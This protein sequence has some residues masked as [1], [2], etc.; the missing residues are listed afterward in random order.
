[1]AGAWLDSR[2]VPGPN[3]LWARPCAVLDLAWDDAD[4]PRAVAAWQS[5]AR[6]ILDAVGWQREDTAV[7]L[8]PGG[9]TLALSAPDDALYAATELN[10]WAWTA[11][12]ADLAGQA[13]VE[14]LAAAAARL[15]ARIAAESRPRMMALKAEAARRG[16][17]FMRDD[18]YVS[19]GMGRWSRTWPVAAHPD[20]DAV[21]WDELGNLPVAVVTGTNGKS[22]T[23]R[24]L[25]AMC[26]AAGKVGGVTSTDFVK[27]GEETVET[28]D[29]AG[30]MGARL[31]LRHRRV[32]VAI[33]ETAR[34]GMLRRGLGMPWADAACIT[35]IAPDHLGEWG[36]ADLDQLADVKFIVRHAARRLV[37]NAEDA[38]TLERAP[39]CAQ[40]ITWF[41]TRD[42]I[43]FLRAHAA[44]NGRACVADDAT[45]WWCEGPRREAVLPLAEVPL[46]LGGAA[47][48]NVANA[49]AAAAVALGIGL[50]LAAVRDG[51]RS[52]RSDAAANPGRLN[53][54]ELGGVRALVDFAHNPH[55]Q[56]AL[57]ALARALPARRRLVMI[58]HAGDRSDADIR[59]VALTAARAGL[60]R[61]LI[62]EQAAHLRGRAPGEIPGIMR[63]ALRA[64]GFPDERVGMHASELDATRAALAWAQP[65]D[66][67]LVLALAQRHEVLA[68]LAA[69]RAAGWRPGAAVPQPESFTLPSA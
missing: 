61:I 36:I 45:L 21:P 28:G 25:G 7:R 53:D 43:A 17:C 66:L 16:V 49:A 62:K 64:A 33:L 46:T 48:F 3:V 6:Q 8:F 27:V 41:A 29:W 26:G 2:R 39:K 12:A 1:M 31:I 54:F 30:P 42:D 68:Y 51:L 55:G 57:Y 58:G 50:P 20:A 59:E 38:K 11:A 67:L 69:V 35:N 24:L 63:A 65:G 56:E 47:R 15:R 40:P 52:F 22:T 13:V 23:T 60:D 10:E 4:A 32:E 19:C 14:D 34:G 5:R 37:L 18:R 44:A 9:A